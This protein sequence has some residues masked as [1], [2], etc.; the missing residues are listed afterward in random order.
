MNKQSPH[1][2][3]NIV[4]P[5]S[6]VSWVLIF[7]IPGFWSVNYLV[8]RTAPAWIAPHALAFSRWALAAALLAVFAW[9]ELRAKRHLVWAD[10]WHFLALGML[11]MWICGA[12]MYVASR[13]SLTNNIAL[14]YAVSPVF[15]VLGS[16][17]FLKE[18][19]RASQ[20]FG[21]VLALAGLIH[22]VIRG[23]W[24]H[25]LQTQFVAGD[26][27]ILACA[28][29]WAIYSVLLKKWPSP[30]SP[31]A[32]LVLI[33]A[34]G[35][36][37]MLL[38]TVIEAASHLPLT[39]TTWGWQ[40]AALIAAAAVFP[41]AGAYLAYAMLQKQIGASRTALVL[42]LGPLY[43]AALAWFVLGEPLHFYHAVGAL[44]IFPGIF[45]ASRASQLKNKV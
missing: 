21:M 4:A 32:R 22:V 13:T 5:I 8:G 19:L 7:A 16:A 30:F 11:G 44:I 38:L 28:V 40:T 36:L 9:P 23:D 27:W 26:W 10:R 39:Q 20:W 2:T 6:L 41:G 25:I 14:I 31:L 35:A 34:A 45:L 37:F 18:Q 3:T 33:A 12:W 15:I 42:Y 1:S 43:A 24:L 17:L 29:A